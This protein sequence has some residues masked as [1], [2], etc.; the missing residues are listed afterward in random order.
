M[1]RPTLA[2][3]SASKARLASLQTLSG[4]REACKP[5]I[6]RN[7]STI[8][9]Q[10]TSPSTLP[11]LRRLQQSLIGKLSNKKPVDFTINPPKFSTSSP[12]TPRYVGWWMLATSTLVFGIVALG[13]I[14]RLTESGLSMVDWSVVGRLPPSTQAEWEEYFERYKQFPEYK[15]LNKGMT[16]DEFKNIFWLEYSHRMMGR[17]IGLFFAI[18]GLFFIA[19]GRVKSSDA[20]KRILAITAMIGCQGLLGWYMVKSGLDDKLIE[21]RQVP[22]VSQYRL[23]AHLGSAFVIY[24]ATL[25]TGWSILSG[26]SLALRSPKISA[27]LQPLGRFKSFSK[28][29][30][31]L[32]FITA[33]S[34]AFV[35]GLDAGLIYNTFPKMADRWIPSDIAALSPA[36]RNIFENPA[37]VQFDH[38]TLAMTTYGFVA[39]LW[40]WS[41]RLPLSPRVKSAATITFA[42]AN[43]QVALGI[44]TL[45]WLVPVPLAAAHQSGSLALLTAATWLQHVLKTIP[46]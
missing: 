26:T 5:R 8:S 25:S 34:G 12:Q 41:R 42:A 20:K 39:A 38:R 32:I 9:W 2:I 35:A 3:V 6:C 23:A 24:L 21:D 11:I 40:L 19:S 46:K 29:A 16:V 30:T 13:G 4:F 27:H 37:T 1:I 10:P 14:T 45:L 18:P 43:L 22:R 33:I 7:F 28:A 44:S 15:V 36:W 17:V 31:V